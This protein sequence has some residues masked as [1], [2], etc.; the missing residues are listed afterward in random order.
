MDFVFLLIVLPILAALLSLIGRPPRTKHKHPAPARRRV[1]IPP[2][3]A[4]PAWLS[5]GDRQR[6][7]HIQQR[8]EQAKQRLATVDQQMERIFAVIQQG[9]AIIEQEAQ[10]FDMRV[11]R[12][13][14]QGQLRKARARSEK[15]TNQALHSRQQAIEAEAYAENLLGA[16]SELRKIRS[17]MEA[18][19]RAA[20]AWEQLETATEHMVEARRSEADTWMTAVTEWKEKVGAPTHEEQMSA[21]TIQALERA[22]SAKQ[23]ADELG[24]QIGQI[25]ARLKAADRSPQWH[26]AVR[27]EAAATTA[28]QAW[29]AAHEARTT[30]CKDQSEDGQTILAFRPPI[31]GPPYR[32]C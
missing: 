30:V 21:R 26:V 19:R 27:L 15:T 32:S 3:L 4:S 6:L 24:E 20:T 25:Q 5:V 22:R 28:Q 12:W 7:H 16:S 1:S 2:H 9:Q 10:A 8:I 14:T 31:S 23:K 11:L 13:R 29:E 18:W 17:V